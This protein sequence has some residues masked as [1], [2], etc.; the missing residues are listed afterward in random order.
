MPAGPSPIYVVT[1]A[2]SQ[3]PGYVQAEDQPLEFRHVSQNILNRNG[4]INS[5]NGADTRQV[6]LDFI[7]MSRLDNVTDLQHLNDCKD[8]YRTAMTICAN[9][10]GPNDLYIGATDRHLDAVPLSISAPIEAGSNRFIKYRVTFATDPYY[11]A[12]TPVTGSFSGNTT[13]NITPT[14]NLLTT[15]PKFTIPSGVTAFTATHAASD[16]VVDFLRGSVAGEVVIHTS[17]FTVKKSSTGTDASSTM[18]NVNFGMK[19]TGATAMSIV[20]TGF[21]GS[22]TVTVDLYPRYPL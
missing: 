22:G 14:G 8:Q 4:A 17:R 2:G 9:A 12:T 21:A 7:V 13:V 20:V 11:V 10:T 19:H 16:K 3:F 18:Q 15:Y 6:S 5:L 1:Y